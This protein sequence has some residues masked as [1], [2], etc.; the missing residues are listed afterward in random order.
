MEEFLKKEGIKHRS[1]DIDKDKRARREFQ[2]LGGKG[3]PLVKIGERVIRG[4]NK[5][6]IRAALK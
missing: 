3:V 2:E 6:E 1:Y 4:F 5:G